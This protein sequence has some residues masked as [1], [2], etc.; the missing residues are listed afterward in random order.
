MLVRIAK[1]CNKKE[2]KIKIVGNTITKLEGCQK[3]H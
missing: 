2:K 3:I 1:S